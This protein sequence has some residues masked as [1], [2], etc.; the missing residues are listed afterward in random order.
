MFADKNRRVLVIDD[1]RAIHHDFRKILCPPTAGEEALDATETELFGGPT[2]TVRQTKFQVDSAYQGEQGAQMVKKALES[3]LPYAMAFID[4]RMPPGWDGVE[5]TRKI[6]EF[7]PH[8]QV[9]LCTAYSDYSW[10]EVFANLA[11]RDGLLIL[12]KPFDSVEAF[13]MAYALTEKWW[14]HLQNR[15]KMEELEGR[16]AERTTELQHSN[17]ALQTEVGEHQRS[18]GMLLESK[19]FA[20][21][22]AE[23]STSIIYIYDLETRRTVYTN[24]NA[25]EALGY[26]R[27]QIVELGDNFLSTVI[28]PEDLPRIAQLHARLAELTDKCIVD[29]ELR[30]K[31]A[32]GDWRWN[33]TRETVF[34][35]HPNGAIWQIL[36]T[37]QDITE[38]KR[39]EAQLFQSQK[40]ETVGKLAGGI[41]HEFNSILTAIIG[42]SD[43]LLADLPA[44]SPLVKNATAIHG[45]A[46]RAAT[47]TRQ[48][49]AYGRRQ[50]LQPEI[51][52]LNSILTGME[53][54]LRHL[55]GRGTD[56]RVVHAMG[57]KPV[58]AD[59]GQIEEVIMNLAMNAAD[60]M[61][62]GGKFTL[63]TANVTLDQAYANRFAEV[64]AGEYVMVAVSD[65]GG[66]M[67][68]EVKLRAFEPFFTTKGVGQGTGL[69]LSTCYGIIKQSG[70]HIGV[71]SELDKGT[72]FKI[73]LPQV[74]PET[75]VPLPRPASRALPRGTETILLVEDDPDLR[76]MATTLLRQLGYT[77]WPAADGIEA[78][79]LKRQRD[80]EHIDLLFTDLVMPHTSG[81][82]LADRVR[83]LSPNTKTLFTSA[84]T[85][86]TLVHQGVLDKGVALLQKPFTPS[87][88]AHKLRELLNRPSALKSDTT[89]VKANGDE[90]RRV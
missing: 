76:D 90:V 67:S 84:Y 19:R 38:R 85:E 57:L 50:T 40:L 49:L 44:G 81:K 15:R 8:L 46:E 48:L 3:G 51:L 29:L 65:S 21:S 80:T 43:L 60:A 53:S 59:A 52:D 22:I 33:W 5:T 37:A 23:N 35:R 70:G 18:E 32:S 41:A 31:D 24:R 26:S 64:K 61:P 16:V 72:T 13:Q 75:K 71:Y 63:E 73:Y 39:L 69:G 62:Q 58:R 12:K 27:A 88:L 74:E 66:G 45:A 34:K 25:A 20:E 28:H 54:T 42:Q 83:A 1:N 56:A 68:E 6:W 11:H 9:V 14:L 10:D 89:P 47:L 82:E 2:E 78:L 36:G 86:N 55:L 77:V 7:D 4:V 87:A 79:T 17:H 30:V